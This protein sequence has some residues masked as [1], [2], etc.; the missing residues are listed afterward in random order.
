[1]NTN[2]NE[3]MLIIRVKGKAT[4]GGRIALHDLMRLG[5]NVQRA[6]ER[7]ARVL[8]GH[9]DSRRPGRKP[10]EIARS[11]ALEVVALKQGSFA[12][13]FDLPK[14]QFEPMHLGVEAVE[15]LLEGLDQIGTN[16]EAL[17]A[18]YDAG[19]LHSLR[20]MGRILGRGIDTIEA[21]SRTQRARKTFSYTNQTRQRI[22][23]RIRGP[24][25]NL[26]SIEGRL[27]MADFQQRAEQCRIHPAIGEPI[28]CKFDESLEQTVYEYLRSQVRITGETTEDPNTGRISSITITDIEPVTLEGAEF[29]AISPD[30]FWHDKTLD[31][32][33]SEQ[34]VGPVTRL[35]D[36]W[37]AGSDLWESDD[38]FDAFVSATKGDGN[39]GA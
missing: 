26:R 5:N 24:V 14:E 11:C 34:V 12:V 19:V 27:L 23:E 3:P 4:E 17:P 20:D 22:I 36:V 7:V 1:M 25:S 18:G 15:K 38:D 28:R 13:A 16:G 9:A 35:E 2:T 39:Q 33:A 31:Q 30:A 29:D 10:S 8:V 21:E 32:L 37:G 6:V